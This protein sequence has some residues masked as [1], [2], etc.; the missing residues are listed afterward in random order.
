MGLVRNVAEQLGSIGGAAMIYTVAS[1]FLIA[2]MGFPNVRRFP[3]RYLLI[4]GSLF[5][6]YEIF[7]AL[8]L[9]MANDRHQA[10]EMA[11]INYLWPALTVLMAVMLSKNRTHWLVYPSIALA[12]LGVAWSITGDQ[13]LSLSQISINVATNPLTYF[14]AFSGAFIWAIYCNITQTLSEG[15]NAIVPF[16]MATAAMLWIQYGLSDEPMMSLTLGSGFDLVIT[17]ICMGSGYAL[18]NRA[19]IGGNMMLL[20]TLSYF[21]PI[22]STV[23]SGLILGVSLTASFWQ[24]VVMV[25]IGSLVCWWVTRAKPKLGTDK[26]EVESC[27]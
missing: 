7:L 25:T 13:G 8:A 24:G 20:A 19:I 10:M 9:G 1:L 12:F 18:W 2:V 23:L 16:F 17:G 21:T 11:V 27:G 6:C 4:G 22:F 5:V 26:G 15:K 3:K 14:F